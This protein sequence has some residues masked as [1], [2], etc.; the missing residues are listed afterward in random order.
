MKCFGKLARDEICFMTFDRCHP[1][2]STRRARIIGALGAETCPGTSSKLSMKVVLSYTSEGLLSRW[3]CADLP[4]QRNTWSTCTL[5][6]ASLGQ[7]L[8]PGLSYRLDFVDI[9]VYMQTLPLS[10]V[11]LFLV[12]QTSSIGSIFDIKK[13][14][15]W[16]NIQCFGYMFLFCIHPKLWSEYSASF[17]ARHGPSQIKSVPLPTNHSYDLFPKLQTLCL[18]EGTLIVQT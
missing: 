9:E 16:P 18:C 15:H 3:S 7:S 6:S 2:D 10:N 13:P 14:S 12:T 8:V 17:C 4:G 11:R 5:P 1:C